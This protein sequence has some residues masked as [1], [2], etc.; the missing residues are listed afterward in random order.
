M[1]C[2]PKGRL[3]LPAL[4]HYVIN[5]FRTAIGT[6]HYVTVFKKL[7]YLVRQLCVCKRE[8]E[9][10]REVLFQQISLLAAIEL[11]IEGYG[12]LPKE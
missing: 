3:H 11:T 10:E 4:D 7:Q 1:K 9:R 5:A 12:V 2:R 8:R 6:V